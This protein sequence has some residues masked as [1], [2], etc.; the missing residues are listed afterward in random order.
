MRR[1]FEQSSYTFTTKEEFSNLENSEIV[2]VIEN[3]NI[4][5]NNDKLLSG[6]ENN[7]LSI[8]NHVE[9]LYYLKKQIPE[10]IKTILNTHVHLNRYL[11]VYVNKKLEFILKSESAI[12]F[13]EIISI[14]NVLSRGEYFKVFKDYNTI[15]YDEINKLFRQYEKDLNSSKSTSKELFNAVFENYTTL[16]QVFN[17]LCLINSI[18]IKRKQ[19]IIPITDILT[20]T[21]NIL[22]FTTKLS[23]SHLDRLNNILGQ[24]L[25]YFSHL[26]F[27]DSKGKNLDYLIDEYYLLF[28]KICDGY[29]VSLDANFMGNINSNEEEFLRFRNNSSYLLLIMLK[30]LFQN[31]DEDDFFICDSFKKCLL[32]YENTFGMSFVKD[33]KLTVESFREDLLNSLALTYEDKNNKIGKVKNYKTA[34]NDF[35]LEAHNYNVHNL[36]TIHDILLLGEEL[37]EHFYLNIGLTLIESSLIKNDYYEF[38]KLKTLDIIL[39]FLIDNCC[40][41]DHK[42][43]V[44][45]VYNY[46]EKYKTASHLMPMYSKLYLSISS[47]LSKLGDDDSVKEARDI[48]SLFIHINGV[49]LLKNEYTYINNQLLTQFGKYQLKELSFSNDDF[50]EEKLISL[51]KNSISNYLKYKELKIKYEINEEL[52]I[53]IGDILNIGNLNYEKL[54]SS[55]CKLLSAKIFYGITEITIKG[56]SR[57]KSDIVD[58]GYKTYKYPLN[59]EYALQFIFPSVYEKNFKFIFEESKDYIV[60]NI[61]NILS[62]YKKE[63]ASFIDSVTNL[64]NIYKLKIDLN[65]RINESTVFL[66]IYIK[67]LGNITNKYGFAVSKKYLNTIIDKINSYLVDDDKL[68]YI[69]DGVLGLIL[70]D[71]D[72][73]NKITDKIQQLKIKKNGQTISIDFVISIVIGKN[74]IYE[75]S[76][77]TLNKAIVSKNNLLLYEQ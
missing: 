22:K 51:G 63:S 1:N 49:K 75:K 72:R 23:K 14:I 9:R 29:R 77:E 34:L 4:I 60:N 15:N 19:S 50:E 2:K 73:V 58:E 35:I 37:D 56:L 27:V 33:N 39:N 41:K 10:D 71:K 17:K 65:E 24:I 11:I 13:K 3:N 20:E 43:F 54:N 47:Y 46:I 18:D 21:I 25:Y 74:N 26:P 45:S 62:S 67:S 44:K 68:Y 53:I 70:S 76:I 55:I 59:E 8:I 52:S 12:F 5:K 66:Q 48:Y 64:E 42:V 16:L 7:Y 28:E 57:K 38:Y 6:S 36:E 32:L 30:K 69:N 31:F 40:V 61:N